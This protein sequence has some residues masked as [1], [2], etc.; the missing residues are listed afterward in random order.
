MLKNRTLIEKIRLLEKGKLSM[1]AARR[2]VFDLNSFLSSEAFTFAQNILEIGREETL[3]EGYNTGRK[4]SAEILLGELNGYNFLESRIKDYI[5]VAN[6][7]AEAKK[8]EKKD[9][10]EPILTDIP[11]EPG[12]NV[13]E[14]LLS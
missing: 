7:Y 11:A 5:I 12:G 1:T 6:N 9:N 13:G 14:E 2:L 3:R 10:E 8:L 4:K